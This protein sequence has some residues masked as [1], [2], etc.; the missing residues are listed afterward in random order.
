MLALAYKHVSPKLVFD[1]INISG[2]VSVLLLPMKHP[3]LFHW[4]VSKY[5]KLP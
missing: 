3:V 1:K 4:N 5:Q 2:F